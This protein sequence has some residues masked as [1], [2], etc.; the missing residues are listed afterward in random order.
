MNLLE[1]ISRGPH[2]TRDLGRR[3]G[4]LAQAGDVILLVGALGV[5]KTCLTQG[6]AEG[7]GVTEYTAS[8]SFVLVREYQGRFPLFHVDL[9]RLTNLT[10][11]ADLGLDDYFQGKGMTVVEWADRAMDLL[12][13][14]HLL[15]DMSYISPA[16]RRLS[17]EPRGE[18]YEQ[19]VCE[20]RRE[21]VGG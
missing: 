21:L 13:A 5:G 10:E 19:V 14:E 3:I 9:Y 8:P 18:R 16:R 4:E 7:L 11:I 2:Q 12:P 15:I 20:L 6:I 17:F 1:V